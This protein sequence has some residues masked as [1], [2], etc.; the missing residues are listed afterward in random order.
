M[1]H[2]SQVVH[3]ILGTIEHLKSAVSSALTRTETE[4]Q[5]SV[6]S[7]NVHGCV[8]RDRRRDPARIARIISEIA[9]DIIGL[10]EIYSR[11]R[12]RETLRQL[13]HLADSTGLRAVHGPTLRR[14][15][16][17]YGNGLLTSGNV[18]DVRH[19]DLS[20]RGAEPRAAL[21][22]DVEIRG[23]A[24][25]VIVTHLGLFGIER[26]VQVR[27]LLAHLSDGTS[28]P[29][30]LLGDL[31]EWL[32]RSRALRWLQAHLGT[33]RTPRTFPAAFP[34]FRLDR[35]WVYPLEALVDVRVHD[36]PAAR[37]AS[38]HLPILARIS[39]A[40]S[41]QGAQVCGASF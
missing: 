29:T 3:I 21:D 24:L 16:A 27:R 15:A 8:G 36:T 6:A 23:N 32:P 25:R 26:R 20:V 33:I 9:P 14:S 38:D 5:L 37:A 22:A 39:H 4:Q 13:E 10:Q 40:F 17:Y 18:T 7:Y 11:S 41:N 31:N 12:T 30:M 28:R 2:R 35:I 19:V 1:K 34:L